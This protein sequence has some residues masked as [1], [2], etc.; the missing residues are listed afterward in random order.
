MIYY[1]SEEEIEL[2]QKSCQLVSNVLATV[3]SNIKPGISSL[4]LDSI[5]EEFI[6]DHDALPAFKGYNG[7]P[8]SL[9]VSINDEVVHGIP[10]DEPLKDGDVVSVDVGVISEGYFGDSAYTFA[11]GEVDE[12]VMKLLKT[13]NEALYLGIDTA[14]AGKRIG[15]IGYAI[16]NYCEKVHKYG[17]VRELVG[18]GI[19]KSLHEEPEVPNFGKRGNGI[20]LNENLVIAIEP[21][22]NLGKRQVSTKSDGWT[23]VTSDGKVSAHYEHTIVIRRDKPLILTSHKGV[24]EALKNNIEIKNIA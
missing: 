9:C 4:Q 7:F 13:T 14:V 16:Q 22:V 23:I 21:M 1:K 10:D 24:E 20:K 18:H 19:G 17:V 8:N 11:V 3:A 2:M 15:D 6:K 5:A 12:E